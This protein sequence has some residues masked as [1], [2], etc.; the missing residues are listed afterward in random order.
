[1]GMSEKQYKEV[2]KSQNKKAKQT[3]GDGGENRDVS[4]QGVSHLNIGVG[5]DVTIRELAEMVKSVVGFTGELQWDHSKP[6]GT[7]RKLLDVSRLKST[8]WEPMVSLE[9]GIRRT[10]QWY[11]EISSI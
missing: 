7:P 2:S 8:G 11:T 9:E 1:M 10:Y 5:T 3:A 4:E 6:D